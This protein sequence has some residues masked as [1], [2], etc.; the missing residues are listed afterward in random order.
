[1][2]NLG[3]DL[4]MGACKLFGHAGSV[5]LP[6]HVAVA[7]GRMI[8]RLAGM[9]TARPP[10]QITIDGRTYYVG[11]GAHAW[12]RPIENMDYERLT[13]SPEIR[14]IVYAALSEYIE[15]FRPETHLTLY[16]G[17]PLEPLSGPDARDVV[18]AVRDWLRG[19]HAWTVTRP[20]GEAQWRCVVVEDV[21]VTSQPTGA[22]FDYLLDDAGKFVPARK[23]HARQ[24]IGII[25]VGFNTVELLVVQDARPV[26]RFT[27]GMTAGARRLLELVNGDNLYSLGELDAQLRSGSLDVR[28]ALPIW[29]R[30]VTGAVE[31]TWGRSWRRFAQVV[32]V[33]GGAL[34]LNGELSF[35][36]RAHIPDEPVM[37][38]ARGL[39][40]LARMEAAR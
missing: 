4:G 37:A 38:I 1:M 9:K 7:D 20:N 13:G 11:D 6:S 34:L 30:E 8:S 16:V 35:A 40:K 39:Y 32:V 24:E 19:E 27:A 25:S 14:V 28:A 17:M 23:G 31:R 12:G 5:H 26:N 2:I 29:A 36:G 3:L 15:R 22:L 33:G 10:M 21:R 18:S